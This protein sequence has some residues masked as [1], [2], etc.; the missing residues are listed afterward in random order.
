[1]LDLN[2]VDNIMIAAL[3]HEKTNSISMQILQQLENAI[4]RL[5]SEESIKGL[6]LTGSGRFF[7]SGFY[8]PA[9]Y[10]FQTEDEVTNWF[11]YEEE[12]L[13]KLFTCSK[14]VVAALNGHTV[15]GG[16][17]YALACDYI[18]A[19]NNPKIKIGMSEINI[20]LS[21]PP[22]QTE[23]MRYGLGTVKN[24]KDIIFSA[25]MI[26]P[27]HAVDIGIIDEL[28]ED[29][30]SLIAKAKD[31]VC[32]LIDTP[33][34]PFIMLKYRH[35]MPHAR[36]MRQA[37]DDCAWHPFSGAFVDEN[38]KHTLRKIQKSME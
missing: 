4:D 5:N 6:V 3:N 34:R 32:A 37:L 8:L 38:V 18:L 11:K 10:N 30:E 28:L 23:V 9:F 15:A 16:L 27:A 19:L 17:I 22:V 26:N 25:R 13:L 35:R 24:Y 21:L 2:T 29:N 14:P 36:L 33:G 31:K 1:M 12:V 20:G 7:S